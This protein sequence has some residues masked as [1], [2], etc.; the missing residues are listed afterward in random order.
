M[1]IGKFEWL[2]LSRNA[3]FFLFCLKWRVEVDPNA[4]GE[5]VRKRF[6][7]SR[8]PVGSGKGIRW[9]SSVHIVSRR[10]FLF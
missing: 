10:G 7:I 2:T 3:T 4:G 1:K 8:R 6:W 5:I 9:N